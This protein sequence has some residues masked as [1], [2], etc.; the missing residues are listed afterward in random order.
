MAYTWIL[1]ANGQRARVVQHDRSQQAFAELAGFIYPAAAPE[2]AHSRFARKLAEYV[3]H[4]LARQRCDHIALV[5]TGPMLGALQPRLSPA[6]RSHLLG[7]VEADFTR[8][9]DA[10]LQQR[11]LETLGS[12]V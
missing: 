8:C 10:E 4:G 3:N 6:A 9:Q 12:Q 11:L 1:V 2:K 7:S 5:A